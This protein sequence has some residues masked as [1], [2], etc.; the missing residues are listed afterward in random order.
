MVAM[1][2][3]PECDEALA[4]RPAHWRLSP[5]E[6]HPN[7]MPAQICCFCLRPIKESAHPIS[8]V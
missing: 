1:D 3:A 5:A 7:T 6:L 8:I 4:R 2:G